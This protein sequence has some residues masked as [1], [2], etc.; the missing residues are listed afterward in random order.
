M[1]RLYAGIFGCLAFL[2]TLTRGALGGGSVTATLWAAWGHLWVFAA[3]GLIVGWIAKRTVEQSVCDQVSS[4]LAAEE[5]RRQETA[6]GDDATDAQPS[7][8][9]AEAAAVMAGA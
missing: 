8:T 3:I 2:T 9:G 4:R 5:A 7:T 1:A 6:T